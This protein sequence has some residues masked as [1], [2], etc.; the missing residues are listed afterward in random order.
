MCEI[1]WNSFQSL[2]PGEFECYGQQSIFSKL[3]LFYLNQYIRLSVEET[4]KFRKAVNSFKSTYV[5]QMFNLDNSFSLKTIYL[6]FVLI[7]VK[8]KFA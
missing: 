5:I 8:I 6:F 3:L 1:L 4:R 2:L 7:L